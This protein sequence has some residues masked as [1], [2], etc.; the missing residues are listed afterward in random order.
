MS[1]ARLGGIL[2]RHS[3][4][5]LICAGAVL[6]QEPI[7]D[8]SFLIEEA[9][10]QPAGVVQ[11]I[12]T[13]NRPT[14][15][16]GWAYSFTQEWPVMGMRHQVSYT[17]PVL[18]AGGTGFG[19]LGLNYRYQIAG[20]EGG[21]LAIAPRASLLLATGDAAKGFG[22]GT[23]ALQLNL[24]VSIEVT[25]KLT[26]H[27]NTGLTYAPNAANVSGDRAATSS[28]AAGGSLIWLV[29]SKLN[30]MLESVWTS[31]ESVIGNDDTARS[32]ALVLVPGVR[33][34]FDLAGDLQVVPGVAY[35]MGVGPDRGTNSAFFYLSIEHPFT[36]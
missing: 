7:K 10:N 36:R 35:V 22:A 12:S 31:T 4:L 21:A 8:N 2:G 34:A 1:Y 24:P 14:V 23:A 15:G 5:S 20:V 3:I 17:V 6:A 16:S 29:T 33:R 26:A 13:F 18:R 19:D 30:F 27:A 11:H 25:P 9:Y 28:F 32:S